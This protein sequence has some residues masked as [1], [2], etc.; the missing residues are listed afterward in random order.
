MMMTSAPWSTAQTMPSMMSLSW[1]G[2]SAPRTVTGM[3]VHAVVADAGD[4]GAVVGRG[5]DDARHGGAVAV[6]VGRAVRAVEDVV[7]RDELAGEVGM[8][9]VDAGVEDRDDR[10]ARRVDGAVDLVPP[11][12]GQ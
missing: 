11:D 8:R 4:A 7:P 12:L 1:P 9:A 5:G 2:P 6:R 3:T 10:G